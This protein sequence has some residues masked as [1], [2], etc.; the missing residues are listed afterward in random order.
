MYSGPFTGVGIYAFWSGCF[1][2]DLEREAGT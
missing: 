1:S 2:A